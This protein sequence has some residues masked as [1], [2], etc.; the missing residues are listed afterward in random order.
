VNA[1][2]AL[3]FVVALLVSI[4]LHEAGHMV[5]AR[6]AGGKVTEFFVGFGAKLW[7]FRRGETEYGFKAIPAGGYVKI[8]GMTDLD[9]VEEGDE[10]RALKNKPARSRLL[11]LAAGSLVH[12]LIATVLFF[13]IPIVFGVQKADGTAK[14]G[15][16]AA[17]M[18][19]DGTTTGCDPATQ[20]SPAAQAGLQQ[21][22][23]ITAVDGKPI[24]DF[25][26]LT[27]A[28]HNLPAGVR[29]TLVFKDTD[30]I[31]QTTTVIPVHAS[32]VLLNTDTGATG[33]ASL[34]GLRQGSYTQHYNPI[35][36]IGYT[37][38]EFWT[39]TKGTFSGLAS[40]P[41]SIPKLFTS[42]VD[43]TQ[44]SADSP[45]SVVGIAEVTGSVIGAA[46][47]A[48]FF[49][50]VASVNVFVGV[51]NL[52][53]ILPLDGGH[54]AIL[55]YE[56]ARKRVYRILRKPAPDRVDLNK[57][58]PV[59]YVFLLVFGGLMILLLAADITNP[60]KLPS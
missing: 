40:I 35:S 54:I 6:L 45:M 31:T 57:L 39:V 22:D 11:T 14:I 48:G 2:G 36:A 42:T 44:R 46:G 53:P 26:D 29:A 16:V 4:V 25:T 19:A 7:S 60:L 3:L 24:K 41:S 52:L 58:L 30:G 9:E 5:C 23:V 47:F 33:P 59:A 21:G 18:N 38:S 43:H 50:L 20:P 12:F 15:Q 55:L 56:E 51:F 34:I 8:V 27:T 10:D 13:L 28:L 49:G 17:C 1:L 32:S 37:G